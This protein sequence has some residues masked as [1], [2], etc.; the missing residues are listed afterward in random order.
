MDVITWFVRAL[1]TVIN[2]MTYQAMDY[3]NG[4]ADVMGG[5]ERYH[6]ASGKDKRR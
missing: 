3:P 4:T 1:M 2:L 6:L 5:M